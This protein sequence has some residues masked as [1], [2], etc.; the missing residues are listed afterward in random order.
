[1]GAPLL[2]IRDLAIGFRRGQELR[3]VVHGIDLEI[4]ENETLALVGESGC[5]KTV[6]AQSILRLYPE[7]WIAYPR[8]QVLFEGRDILSLNLEEVRR[9]RGDRI[10]MV[11]QEPMSSLNPLHTVQWQLSETLFLHRGL[12]PAAARGVGLEW[13]ARVGLS[14]PRQKLTAYPHQLSGGER[15]RV[16]IAMALANEPSLLIADEPTTALDV[17]IQAQILELLARL[18]R[19]LAMS[20]LFITH[21]LS[22]VRRIADRVAVMRAGRLVE[23]GTVE[24]VFARPQE[25]Y[26]RA[27]LAAEP[28]ARPPEPDP[29]RP[30]LLEVQDLKVWFPIKRGF[31]RI[32][33]GHVKA[34][35]GVT[36]T[37][38]RGQTLGVVG[39]SGSGKTTLGKAVLRLEAS[40]GTILFQGQALQDLDARR[41]RP[42]RRSMQV[43]FQDPYGSLSPRLS[44][45]QIVGE[46]L[47]VHRIGTSEERER[48]IADTLRE[49]GLD[50]EERHRYPNEFSGGQR[51][52]IALARALVLKP[53]LIILD[54]PTSSLDRTI[55]FQVVQLLKDLQARHGLT[56]IFISHDL[57]LVRSLC[58]EIVI[59]QRGRIV[60]SGPAR[61]IFA[62]PREAYTQELLATAFGA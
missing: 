28:S 39:E 58:H 18:K 29:S 60:E 33:R 52:R 26:T 25:A 16:M 2:E 36:L 8:G 42:L 37:A 12:S 4:R 50:P 31:L 13:L 21:D 43:I 10:S 51:Q 47:E 34:V 49:V 45:G 59:M 11:F 40:Q 19:E 46:G 54:E 7:R 23:T 61:D 5:G 22:I 14:D 41:L 20:V 27:L 17:T 32:T 44:V 1:M 6:T 57:R 48:L 55:Q 24:Q 56:Y 9:L 38:R 30:P 62:R 3:P 35:D 53:E 15:Q